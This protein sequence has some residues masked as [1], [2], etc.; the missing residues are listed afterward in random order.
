M[1]DEV[2]VK[3]YLASE[4]GE[5]ILRG[6]TS[7][8]PALSVYEQV[9]IYK[10]SI[11]GYLKLNSKLWSSRGK[12]ST[13]FGE[14]LKSALA[15]LPDYKGIAYRR[16]NLLARQQARYWQ[17]LQSNRPLGEFAFCSSSSLRA[18]ALAFPGNTFFIIH[19]KTGK[20]IEILAKFGYHTEY[21]EYEVLF[22]PNTSFEVL[23]INR[24]A[25]LLKIIMRE[26]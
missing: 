2:Y 4:L 8:V 14:R 6:D 16:I 17:A 23:G 20:E 26:V 3:T 25:G 22:L 21:N 11:D 15:K 12:R 7:H 9:L 19:S 10:Y 18:V 1:T 24:N 13:A 5:V